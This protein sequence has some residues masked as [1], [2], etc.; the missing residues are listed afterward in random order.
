MAV[1]SGI[2]WLLIGLVTCF[3]GKRL[4]RIV[5][6]L[7]GF[8]LGYYAGLS[9]LA[10]QGEL[11][12]LIVG[13]VLGVILAVVFYTLYNYAY[14]LFGALLGAALAA[15]LAEALG[16]QSNIVVVVILGVGAAIGA[17][18]GIVLADFM[19]RLGTSFGGAIQTVAGVGSLAA[20]LGLS[21][22]LIDLANTAPE[23]AAN[24]TAGIVSIF[25]AGI[26]GVIGYMYQTSTASKP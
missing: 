20:A 4:Y 13:V 25:A 7:G 24:T 14:A 15:V 10:G 26:L 5:L 12:Q 17:A 8:F 16:V 9:L 2:I 3:F 19:I 1:L 6:A 11:T 21:L 18:I 23:A 22:P